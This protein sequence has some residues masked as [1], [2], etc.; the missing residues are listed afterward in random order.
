MEIEKVKVDGDSNYRVLSVEE[1]PVKPKS[2]YAIVGLYFYPLLFACSSSIR[3]CRYQLLRK[4]HIIMAGSTR[5]IIN[6]R[7]FNMRTYVYKVCFLAICCE[8]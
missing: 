5:R 4:S 6:C 3:V 1:K 2:N 8:N 7:Y